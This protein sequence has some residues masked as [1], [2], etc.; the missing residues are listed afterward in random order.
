MWSERS[1]VRAPQVAPI[2]THPEDA[3]CNTSFQFASPL[4]ISLS[5]AAPLAQR[6][7]QVHHLRMKQKILHSVYVSLEWRAYAFVI[8][9]LFL[10]ATTGHLWQA[11]LS[12]F[13]L[14][15]ILLISHFVWYYFRQE[16]RQ[17]VPIGKA[18]VETLKS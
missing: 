14:Q 13:G 16:S 2:K 18:G 17:T 11:T 6:G 7:R 8:T 10:W 15:I 12:A 9:D 1:W 4:Y 3:F 5:K